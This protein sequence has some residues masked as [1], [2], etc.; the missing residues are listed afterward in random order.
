MDQ[1]DAIDFETEK[2]SALFRKLLV[3]TLVGT[4]S[5]AAMITID[6]IFVGHGVGSDGVAAINIVSPVYQIFSGLGLMIGTGCSVIASIHMARQKIKVAR[7]N[8]TQALVF[9]TLLT[10]VVCVLGMAFPEHAARLLGASET[11][12]AQ[13]SDY[14]FWMMPSYVFEMWGFIGVFIIR[15]DGAPKVAMWCSI[16][17]A[18]MNILLDWIMI[19]PLG[20]GV[21]GAAIATATSIM[22]GGIIMLAYLLFYAKTLR[23]L[24]LKFSRKSMYLSIRNVG[25]HCRVGSPTLFGEM[26][27]AVLI[28]MGNLMFMKYLGDDGVAAFGVACYYTPFFFN[29]GNAVAHSAQ[30]IISYNYG[31]ARWN[32]VAQARRLLFATA[33]FFGFVIMSLFLLFPHILVAL[34]LDPADAAARIAREGFPYYAVGIPFFILNVA[35][36]GYYQSIERMKASVTFVF[37]R[38]VGLLVP[39]FIILPKLLDIKGIW[40]SM[41]F[42]EIATL[43]VIICWCFIS[44]KQL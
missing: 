42:T 17:C 14:L 39:I 21:K 24:P 34:F 11:L 27:L 38:G 8:V 41:P 6:G 16:V 13:T 20:L 2:V 18:L 43:L 30:P 35:V 32:N 44:K 26:T 28:F 10:T 29:I 1:R 37:L 4:L 40:L 9:S 7:L 5:I 36:V 31:V 12:L 23:L 19:F 15:L 3:P 33:L 25:Y 22:V